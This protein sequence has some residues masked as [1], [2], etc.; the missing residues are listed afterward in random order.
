MSG[1]RGEESVEFRVSAWSV[2]ARSGVRGSRGRLLRGEAVVAVGVAAARCS[3]CD[4]ELR[5]HVDA[6]FR[7]CACCGL[8]LCAVVFAGGR[9]SWI[10]AEAPSVC[11][12]CGCFTFNTDAFDHLSQV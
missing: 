4:G 7:V 5:S 10:A 3:E 12:C 8:L 6:L 9:E 11:C 1:V 2:G